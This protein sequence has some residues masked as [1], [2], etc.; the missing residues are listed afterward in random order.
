MQVGPVHHEIRKP[1]AL[2]REGP[3]V[4]QLPGLAGVPQPHHLAVDLAPALAD[5]GFQAELEQHPRAVGADL[6]A[7]ADLA[8][9]LGPFV[10]LDR[11]APPEQAQRRGQAADTRADH[12]HPHAVS[13]WAPLRNAYAG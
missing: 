3:E 12:D 6:E 8:K 2:H 11:D 9:G 7:G 1:V 10:D 5:R 4:E 13:L